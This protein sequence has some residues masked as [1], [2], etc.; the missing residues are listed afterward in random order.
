[1]RKGDEKRQLLLDAAEK[2]FCQQGYEKTSVQDILNATAMSKG[3][4]Y[5]H[6]A[7]KDE[8][9][10]A[11][12][13]RRAERAA[14]FTAELLNNA[15]TPM[16]RINAVL[17]GFVPLRKEE[18][19]FAALLLPVIGTSEWRAVAM[20]YQDALEKQFLPLL[21]TEIASA[22]AVEAVFP[23]AKD[24]EGVILELVNHCWMEAAAETARASRNGQWLDQPTLLQTLEKY[25]RAIELLL[26]APYG[27]IEIIRMEEWTTAARGLA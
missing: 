11:L 22:A 14:A 27:S 24:L 3:G 2:L 8:V 6:F 5:H 21:K 18:A 7:S 10:T 12:C 4:F 19:A 15:A 16:D 17:Y 13:D 9:M 20:T 25:R 26:D 1:M 23:P